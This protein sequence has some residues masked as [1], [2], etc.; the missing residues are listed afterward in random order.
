MNTNIAK[1]GCVFYWA[2]IYALATALAVAVSV[3]HPEYLNS[4]GT[5]WLLLAC[6]TTVLVIGGFF[7]FM[8]K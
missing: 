4:D 5:Y 8:Y 1:V 2:G 7:R 6:G 3:P